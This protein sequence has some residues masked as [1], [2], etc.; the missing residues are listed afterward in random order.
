[1]KLEKERGIKDKQQTEHWVRGG[2][3]ERRTDKMKE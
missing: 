3:D 1:M 2:T